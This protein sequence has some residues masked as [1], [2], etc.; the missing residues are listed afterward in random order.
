MFNLLTAASQYSAVPIDKNSVL[1]GQSLL[2]D[3][4]DLEVSPLGWH[5]DSDG[6]YNTT[7]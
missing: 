5:E 4:Q 7:R 6:S 1:D 3:P 2:K